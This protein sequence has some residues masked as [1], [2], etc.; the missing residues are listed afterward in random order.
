MTPTA[1]LIFKPASMAD[2]QGLARA[3]PGH[4]SCVGDRLLVSTIV[5]L[6]ATNN[7]PECIRWLPE[8]KKVCANLRI[9]TDA[10]PNS[11]AAVAA[12][13][14]LVHS[15][16]GAVETGVSYCLYRFLSWLVAN[17]A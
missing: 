6:M 12:D 1:F 14:V 16:S 15:F 9:W 8:G 13:C 4:A 10:S 5:R 2:R 11:F 7:F 17:S 3:V